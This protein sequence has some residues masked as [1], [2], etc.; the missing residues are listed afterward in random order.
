MIAGA[1]DDK[2]IID[3]DANYFVSATLFTIT[4]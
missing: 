2:S 3:F 4:L 1:L